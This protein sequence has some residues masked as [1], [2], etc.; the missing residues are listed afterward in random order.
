M[1]L[2]T[3]FDS[4]LG[5]S[6]F[7]IKFHQSN[8]IDPIMDYVKLPDYDECTYLIKST[9]ITREAAQKAINNFN[10]EFQERV[11]KNTVDDFGKLLA[12]KV[13]I[14]EEIKDKK[15]QEIRD[16]SL[17]QVNKETLIDFKNVVESVKYEA[18]INKQQY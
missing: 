9:D 14:T 1:I 11:F 12:D 13:E 17:S 8:G 18:V 16:K 7:S 3:N 5:S 2:F 10:K 4:S 6:V 15:M